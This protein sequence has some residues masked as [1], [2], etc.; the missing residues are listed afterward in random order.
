[1][2]SRMTARI[3]AVALLWL[4][5]LAAPARAQIA[6]ERADVVVELFTSQGCS[7]C[8][9]ANR[10]LG[11]FRQEDGVLALTFAVDMWDYL[12]WADTFAQ[13]EFDQRQRAYGRSMRTRGRVTPQ[14]VLN[15]AQ[16]LN[17]YDWDEARAQFERVRQQSLALGPNDLSITRLSSGRVRIALGANARAAGA[18]VWAVGYEARPMVVA[19][20]GGINRDRSVM[21]YNVVQSLDRVATWDGRPAFYQRRCQPECAVIVQAANGGPILGAAYTRRAR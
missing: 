7:Q 21:H 10:L 8:P 5:A 15:G 19:V 6:G 16:P 13:P 17:T 3:L 4:A 12:G 9:R 11:Q 2:L 1:M 20:T 14:I 18:D